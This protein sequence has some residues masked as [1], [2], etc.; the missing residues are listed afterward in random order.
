MAGIVEHVA[1][2]VLPV[3]F[4]VL[5]CFMPPSAITYLPVARYQSE[6]APGVAG[7]ILV[8]TTLTLVTLPLVLTFWAAG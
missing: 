7:F 2:V 6:E 4:C 5:L 3:L 1:N 8:S